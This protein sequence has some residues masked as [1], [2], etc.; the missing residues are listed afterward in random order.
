ME[1]PHEHQQSLLL[2]RIIT[3]IEKLNE[4]VMVLNKSLQ[5]VNVQNMNVEL[6][7]QMFKNYQSNVLFHLEATDNIKDPA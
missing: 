1:S 3:N 4:A 6:V 7:A 2:S 5:E